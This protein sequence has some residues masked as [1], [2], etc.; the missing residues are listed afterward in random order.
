M[1]DVVSIVEDMGLSLK[2]K[3]Y[4]I[5]QLSDLKN[6]EGRFSY[7]KLIENMRIQ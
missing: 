4:L 7:K 2:E 3:E 5:K 6:A 1:E